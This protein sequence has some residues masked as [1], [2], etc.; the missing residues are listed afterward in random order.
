MGTTL[1]REQSLWNLYQIKKRAVAVNEEP[2]A[3]ALN[4]MPIYQRPLTS[5]A[6]RSGHRKY[7]IPGRWE[8]KL[9]LQKPSLCKWLGAAVPLHISEH[10][11]SA[12]CHIFTGVHVQRVKKKKE[13]KGIMPWLDSRCE[14]KEISPLREKI[15]EKNCKKAQTAR[16][17]S[18][19]KGWQSEQAEGKKNLFS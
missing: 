8:L 6:T 1:G 7:G 19:I 16:Q 13:K 3:L 18:K 14:D 4:M 11:N 17:E 15:N 2:P 12:I 10:L 5:P 9:K